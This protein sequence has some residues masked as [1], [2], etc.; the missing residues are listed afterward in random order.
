MYTHKP[1]G[2]VTTRQGPGEKDQSLGR[3]VSDS[4]IDLLDALQGVWLAIC[5]AYEVTPDLPDL[6]SLFDG[7]DL[8]TPDRA[9]ETIVA[10]MLL[11]VVEVV[12][13][14]SPAY[15]QPCGLILAHD[16]TTDHGYWTLS[17]ET[18]LRWRDLLP[19]LATAIERNL[20]LILAADLIE[21]LCEVTAGNRVLAC[22]LCLP[23][24]VILVSR[25]VLDNNEIICDT[26]QHPFHP[27]ETLDQA[28][29]GV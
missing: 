7:A 5:H 14:Y 29:E 1:L 24:R 18:K 25:S 23:A 27:I 3:T 2:P 15:A 8:N 20:G 22:C 26:C 28:D 10:N 16:P 9:A 11:D 12:G 6:P 13:R 4:S 21:N 17:P 19:P